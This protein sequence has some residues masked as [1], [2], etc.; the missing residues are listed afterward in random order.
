MQSTGTIRLEPNPIVL[1]EMNDSLCGTPTGTACVS[2]CGEGVREVEV[3][4]GSPSG[5]LFARTGPEGGA[6]SASW[7]VNGTVFYLQDV[8][9]GASRTLATAK[10]AISFA[11]ELMEHHSRL[12]ADNLRL[13][14]DTLRAS[15][16]ADRYWVVGGLLLGW[17][18]EGRMLWHEPQDGDFGYFHEDRERLLASAPRLIE[19]GFTASR[20]ITGNNGD[21]AA[22]VFEKDW[23]AFEFAEY[24]R[25]G[26]GFRASNFGQRLW[27]NETVPIEMV[28]QVPAFDLAPMEFL[29]RTWLKPADHDAYLRSVYGQWKK[30]DYAYDYS[31]DDRSIVEIHPWTGSSDWPEEELKAEEK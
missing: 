20:R 10:A 2:W 31:R 4:V 3:R 11:P 21:P 5:P 24:R 17:A 25:T 13:L 9:A 28:C 8:T 18:R 22:F 1:T 16:I 7:I 29:G 23:A 6:K 14:H 19:A 30:R 15:P 26:D 27:V 12:L